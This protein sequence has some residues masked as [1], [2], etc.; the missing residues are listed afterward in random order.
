VSGTL[1]ADLAPSCQVSPQTSLTA[2]TLTLG[3]TGVLYFSNVSS[4]SVPVSISGTFNLSA[5][6]V[7]F[8]EFASQPV[9]NV[10]MRLLSFAAVIYPYCMLPGA[11]VEYGL[12][13]G[14]TLTG[15]MVMSPVYN[16]T[17]QR[18]EYQVGLYSVSPAY[19]L[20]LNK[21]CT[22]FNAAAA[23]ALFYL[24][25]DTASMTFTTACGSTILTFACS[26][27]ST[28]V[29]T[30]YCANIYS[31]ATNPTSAFSQA[32]G[33]VLVPSSSSSSNKGLYGLLALLVIP[34]VAVVAILYWYRKRHGLCYE[35]K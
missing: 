29:A 28:A 12:S 26:G 34:I 16:Y 22:T 25:Y 10:A 33:V 35:I 4:A 32:L 30:T 31:Q 8:I 21:D 20:T 23:N 13:T 11:R 9:A 3:S 7:F 14:G 6:G 18:C 2:T 17:A 27:A 5:T 15:T 1:E 19:T 24:F